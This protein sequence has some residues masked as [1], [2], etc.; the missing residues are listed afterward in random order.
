[1]K[2]S[3]SDK[4]IGLKSSDVCPFFSYTLKGEKGSNINV[5]LYDGLPPRFLQS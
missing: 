5:S 3:K 2:L 1:M 4:F